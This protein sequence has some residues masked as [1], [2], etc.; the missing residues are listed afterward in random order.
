MND[1]LKTNRVSLVAN[2]YWQQARIETTALL[3][4]GR[5]LVLF[6]LLCTLLSLESFA[7]G[8]QIEAESGTLA[9]SAATYNDGAASGGQGVAFLHLPGNAFTL[10]GVPASTT[11]EVFYA[12]EVSGAISYRINGQ[13]AGDISF[14]SNGTWVGNYTSVSV[15]VNIP[16]NASVQIINDQGDAAMNVDYILFSGGATGPTCDDGIQNQGEAGVDCGGPCAACPSCTDGIQNQG[17]ADVD[18]GGPCAACPTCNDGIQNQGEAD[19]DCG[20]PCAACPTCND[21]I[22][23]Q[24][25]EGVDCGGPCAACPP[26]PSST[27]IE[28]ESSSLQGGAQVYND[29][30]ASGGQGVAFLDAVGNGFTLSNVP[31][32]STMEV[33]YASQVSGT[34]SVFVNGQD[35][36]DLNFTSNGVWVGSY[37]SVSLNVNIPA[38]A[39]V[40]I[41]NQSGDVAMNVDYIVFSGSA[42][43]PTC[44]DGVQNQGEAGVDC[45]G[46]CT[47]TCSTSTCTD[48]IQ[49]GDEEGIDCGGSC[50][51]CP[52]PQAVITSTT[53]N[54]GDILVGG[55]GSSQ[56]GFT[57]YTFDNDNGGPF[58]SCEG[59]CANTWPPVLVNSVQQAAIDNLPAEFNGTFGVSGRC[60]GTL[61]IT[62]ND[63]PLYFYSQDNAAGDT[64]GDGV[65][66]VWHAVV[67]A[68]APANCTDGIQNGDETGIDCGGSCAAC[69]SCTDGIQN[70]DETGVD[71]GGS[72]PDACS[73]GPAPSNLTAIE[74]A[75]AIDLTWSDNSTGEDNFH[76]ER[77][78]GS[79]FAE[80]A[81][82][83][84]NTT[85]YS[86]FTV[87]SG[88]YSYR[89]RAAQGGVFSNYS[90]VASATIAG[91][92][93]DSTS[94]PGTGLTGDDF[95]MGLNSDGIAYHEDVSHNPSFFVISLN[96]AGGDVSQ[97]ASKGNRYEAD[98]SGSVS[99]GVVYTMEVRIQGN[100]Y[101]T[102][103]C[104]HSIQVQLGE[105]VDSTPCQTGGSTGGG[106]TPVAAPEPVLAVASSPSFGPFLTGA[107]GSSQPGFTLYTTT[108]S[109]TGGCLDNWPPLLVDD[110]ALVNNPGGITN[111]VGSVLFG[112]VDCVTKYQATLDGEPLYF[113]VG[114]NA[115]G[116]TNGSTVSGWNVA[117]VNRLPKLSDQDFLRPALKTPVNG[118]TPGNFGYVWDIT[119]RTVDMRAGSAIQLQFHAS[120]FVGGVG[121]VLRGIGDP[122]WT[123][124][125]SCNQKEF[126]EAEMTFSEFGVASTTVPG[127][128]FGKYYYFF[129]YKKAG[130]PSDDLGTQLVYSGLFEYDE[131]NPNDRINPANQAQ[132]TS[133]SANWMRF[134]HPRAHD[135]NTELIFN[136][137]N[138]SGAVRALDRYETTVTTGGS[139][140]TINANLP[141]ILRI[142]ALDNGLIFNANPAYVYNTN[143][144]CG[145]NMDY[146]NVITYEI[147][148][149]AGA[150][151]S[152][153]IYNTFQHVT[154]GKGFD[155]SIGDPRLTLAG[156]AS[157]TMEFSTSG[158]HVDLEMDA[159]FTQ[160]LTTLTQAS[161]VDD[162]LEGHHI[163]HGLEDQFDVIQARP[164]F[165][166]SKIGSRA[167]QDCHFRDGRSS[168]V[169]QTPDGPRIAPPV[170]GTGILQHIEGAQA[171]LTWD[172]DVSTVTEQVGNALINDHGVTA[173]SL[174]DTRLRQL[175]AY[176]EFLT[177]PN[178]NAAAY[179]DPDINE[180]QLKFIEVGCASCH[181]ETQKTSSTAPAEFRD[182]YIRPYTDM[183]VH[184]VNGGN[185]R[186]A[187]LWGLGRNIDLLVRNGRG[188]IFMHDGSATTLDG[189]VQAHDGDASGARAAYNAL[190][191][192]DQTKLIKFLETL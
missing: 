123:F 104:I 54:L 188:L 27:E 63:E 56:N 45:G 75:G 29:G 103:Q 71:C 131:A 119:G 51:T 25:E 98:F 113:Y 99:P 84:G 13:D 172:G 76:I 86:D 192:A 92:P 8:T 157:T 153:Q 60:D 162:F 82:T 187:P 146:G 161:D 170:Y 181:Q 138:N 101:N 94:N 165:G 168:E 129:R 21:G 179:L 88:T 124:V 115:A 7:Q 85:S 87:S 41:V 154:V 189:A 117:T 49:N 68:P 136:S 159:I 144:C 59:G 134:R 38:N 62:Y 190:S 26:P 12:S 91:N 191:N 66:G 32:S 69:V 139:G 158:S 24:G 120:E 167:C 16:A 50:G 23:N 15:S 67:G 89:V 30:A 3:R 19:V 10:S 164:V 163:F 106:E 22:Q 107:A 155:S 11:M 147:T 142:E 111:T 171:G 121:S 95:V 83:N 77:N 145:T 61:Q 128:C 1:K 122:D 55:P 80:I 112:E 118:R 178:R 65:N 141:N 114:D 6:G 5:V 73:F 46:P 108:G 183:K 90:N 174:G 4:G 40:Q 36:G 17:E 160:H 70:G 53:S 47:A 78:A 18:C 151:I 52:T 148:I 93:C 58:S 81:T 74:D 9:G 166:S 109:C 156:R 137:Q 102:G 100:N 37:T 152:S 130:L 20:G 184:N 133:R 186:T 43:D 105:G 39:S 180:G 57:V 149:G 169:F 28:A 42:P 173:A 31:A 35:A 127:N 125:C 135:G 132:I 116:D 97:N 64:N 140:T 176:T 14:S 96:G 150:Q 34:I 143:T 175:I 48:G 126:Y 33:F 182:L 110:P 177:V 2:K 185:F 72:C 44:T 79:G